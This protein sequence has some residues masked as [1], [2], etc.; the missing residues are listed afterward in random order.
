ME[1]N[2][3][4]GDGTCL[5]QCDN[6]EDYYRSYHCPHEC[7]LIACPNYEICS[8]QIPE[9]LYN[10][11]NGRCYSCNLTFGKNLEKNKDL[12]ECP[13][14]LENEALYSLDCNHQ[15]CAMCMQKIYLPNIIK[16]HK[17]YEISE[18]IPLVYNETE[19]NMYDNQ[20]PED[21]ESNHGTNVENYNYE[22]KCP[23]CRK[24][25]I[26]SW[27]TRKHCTVEQDVDT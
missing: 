11:H 18:Y 2:K 3:C 24:K 20:E 9:W 19:E 12:S 5:L 27:H 14:C 10:C 4:F 26:P 21:E 25:Y 13:V 1:E 23:L 16:E 6:L 15:L 17:L 22:R 7:R 8:C